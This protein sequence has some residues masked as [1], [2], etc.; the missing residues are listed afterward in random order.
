MK[1]SATLLI[2]E[3]KSLFDVKNGATC[4]DD[5]GTDKFSCDC[6]IP[7]DGE[8]CDMLAACDGNLCHNGGTCT[9]TSEADSQL[10][11]INNL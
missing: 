9:T 11:L 10:G 8:R 1:L 6:D 7:F 2:S 5:E 3:N 4:F